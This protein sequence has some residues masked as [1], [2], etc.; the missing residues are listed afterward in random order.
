MKLCGL[1]LA[2]YVSVDGLISCFKKGNKSDSGKAMLGNQLKNFS[3]G[4]LQD[5]EDYPFVISDQDI[6]EAARSSI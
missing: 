4:T 1:A 2:I 3:D 5:A 6:V